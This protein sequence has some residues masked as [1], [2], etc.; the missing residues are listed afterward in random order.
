MREKDIPIEVFEGDLKD[1]TVSKL[2]WEPSGN[3][4][5]LIAQEGLKTFVSF[6][7]VERSE[8]KELQTFER[9]NI[10]HLFWSPK[11]RFIVLAALQNVQGE[12]E[13]WDCEELQLLGSAEHYQATEVEWDP[14]GRYVASS[15]SYWRYQTENGFNLWDF[16]GQPVLK[17]TMDR[18]KQFLW[19]PRP[20]SLLNKEQMKQIRKRLKDYAD[21]FDEIDAKLSGDVAA[22]AE[23]ERRKVLKQWLDWCNVWASRHQQERELRARIRSGDDN[24]PQYS[25]DEENQQDSSSGKYEVEEIEEELIEE[26]EELLD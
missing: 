6:F 12:M 22:K 10:S 17:K 7:Q 21:E 15:L 24:N 5:A 4:F 13:F 18:F 8:I 1:R 26:T 2:E 3:R 16:K 9:K 20:P 19:R 11:G 23:V 14:S 25:D